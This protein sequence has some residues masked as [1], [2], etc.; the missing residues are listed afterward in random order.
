MAFWSRD[1]I[2]GVILYLLTKFEPNPST[3]S[4]VMTIFSKIQNGY[5]Q[6]F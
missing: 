6:P 1:A 4:E 2:Q 3:L 5:P